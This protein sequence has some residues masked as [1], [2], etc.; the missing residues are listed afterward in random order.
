[1]SS[2]Y[3]ITESHVPPSVHLA[4][5][6]PA[7][8]MVLVEGSRSART[9][10]RSVW[11][12]VEIALRE[13]SVF[14]AVILTYA[15][16]GWATPQLFSLPVPYSPALYSANLFVVTAAFLVAAVTCYLVY[17]MIAVRPR[18]LFRYLVTALQDRIMT[19]DR[20]STILPVFLL[21]PVLMSTFTYF[22]VL[23]PYIQPFELDPLLADWDRIVHFGY[24][25]WVLLQPLLGKPSASAAINFVYHL[26]LFVMFGVVLWQGFSLS[27]P[28]LRMRYLLTFIL[29]WMLLG[30][31]A[32]T[33]LSSAGPVYYGRLTGLPDPFAPLMSYLHHA[34]QSVW[35]PALDVQEMLWQSYL[36]R[37]LDIGRGISAMPSLHVATSFSFALLGFAVSRWLGILFSVF[38]A[39]ILIGSVHLGWHYAIDGYAGI[40]GAWAI[41]WAVGRFLDRPA[42]IRLLWG[43][44]SVPA[45]TKSC[46][47]WGET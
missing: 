13:H 16:F 17:V 30:N 37:D 34:S 42:V 3:V 28:R 5:G 27:R 43:E 35:L 10:P 31:A 21:L 6:D 7:N 19:L 41:W 32:A 18:R 15:A 39:A 11:Q 47:A 33:L 23:I 46:A 4:D 24:D 45:A 22:K 8:T 44:A 1:M 38:T 2:D 26:W 9:W 20:L 40:A 14:V 36:S 25:P 12:K 29:M